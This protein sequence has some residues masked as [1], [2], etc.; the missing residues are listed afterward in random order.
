MKMKLKQLSRIL[1]ENDEEHSAALTKTGFWGKR[2]AG[3]IFLAKDTGRYLL[4]LRSDEVQ[5]PN[6]WGTW[7][8]AIDSNEESEKAAHREA[9]EE[10]GYNGPIELK[11]LWQFKHSASGFTYDNYLAIVPEEFE[12]D[13]NWESDNF[14]W[15]EKGKWPRRQHPGLKALINSGTL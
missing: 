12:P 8:G 4:A 3:V 1:Q 10:T 7:G 5:E 13:L 15:F 11:F 2:G 14:E 6:T 9:T